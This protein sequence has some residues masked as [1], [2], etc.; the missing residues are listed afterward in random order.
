M[1]PMILAAFL[2]FL[3][4]TVISVYGYRAYVRPSRVYDRV[5]GTADTGPVVIAAAPAPSSKDVVVRVIEQIGEKIPLS[6][7]DL[8]SA[9]KELVMAGFRA[10]GSVQIFSG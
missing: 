3:L 9:R 1:L 10:E 8:T 6:S 5:G 4:M 2:F 7:V